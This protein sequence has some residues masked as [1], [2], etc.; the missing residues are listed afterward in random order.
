MATSVENQYSI[1]RTVINEV[2]N[3][4]ERLPS[5][6]NI[7]LRIRRAIS[8][9][10]TTPDSLA[11][12]I[13]KDPALSALLI[14]SAS[15]PLYCRSV[16]PKTLTEVISLLG[17]NEVNNL[18]MLHSVRSLY[19]M[20]TR[21][22]KNLFSNTWK[23]LTFK[24]A[25]ASFISKALHFRPQ[26]QVPMATLLTEIGSLSVLSAV[27]DMEGLPDEDTYFQL[28]RHY[29]KSLG[30]ILLKKWNVDDV[31]V[32]VIK[33]SG[34]W[35]KTWGDELSLIDVINLGLYH[36][37][38]LTRRRSTLPPLE[39]IAA[40]QKIPSLYQHTTKP[41]VLGIVSNGTKEIQEIVNSLS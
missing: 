20:K 32:D 19:V 30:C 3:D 16:S 2:L 13:N 26:D 35:G 22:S 17:F 15:S 24:T 37:V 1:Y 28:C 25:L 34:E 40:Y 39:S 5:L 23:R 31:F 8:E 6:P 14:K 38:M 10:N 9:E 11:Q 33:D 29:S 36:T 4:S 12:L 7:T 21:Q 18:I 27:L 41:N